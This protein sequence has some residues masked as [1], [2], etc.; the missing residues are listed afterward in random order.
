MEFAS[1]PIALVFLRTDDLPG[2]KTKLFPIVS[3]LVERRVECVRKSRN[4]G[5]AERRRQRACRPIASPHSRGNA[6]QADDRLERS[7]K[8]EIVHDHTQ[9]HANGRKEKDKFSLGSY[10]RGLG[11]AKRRPCATYCPGNDNR[12]VRDEHLVEDRQPKQSRWN[13][14]LAIL[15]RR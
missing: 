6:F 13:L 5:V 1:Y 15:T 4:L 12:R 11:N 14:Q 9:E 2:Q 3:K 10:I 7:T 8:R